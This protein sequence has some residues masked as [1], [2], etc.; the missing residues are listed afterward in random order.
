MFRKQRRVS[1]HAKQQ[2][3][4]LLFTGMV[5]FSVTFPS[6]CHAPASQR[7]LRI[8]PL[9]HKAGLTFRKP[10]CVWA[11]SLGKI[12][13]FFPRNISS[14]AWMI[15]MATRSSIHQTHTM[16]DAFQLTR[17]NSPPP[18][19]CPRRPGQQPNMQIT[20][21]NTTCTHLRTGKCTVTYFFTSYQ[22]IN[23]Q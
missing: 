7:I 22:H 9:R 8:S 18:P 3:P 17:F 11:V 1:N 14:A 6:K 16:A 2:L 13:R 10:S 15:S 20:S 4:F 12:P 19:P 23:M 21:T 5:A